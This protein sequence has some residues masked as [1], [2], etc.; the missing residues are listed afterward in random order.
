MAVAMASATSRCASAARAPRAR[1]WEDGRERERDVV[2]V[3]R[4]RGWWGLAL[5]FCC[6]CRGAGVA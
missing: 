1:W 4:R 3:W 5:F 6:G 2:C